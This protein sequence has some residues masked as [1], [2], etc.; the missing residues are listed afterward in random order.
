MH[1]AKAKK[2]KTINFANKDDNAGLYKYLYKAALNNSIFDI[3]NQIFGG[4]SSL[5]KYL[6]ISRT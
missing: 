2:L 3:G 1:I 6:R 5:G 4:Q